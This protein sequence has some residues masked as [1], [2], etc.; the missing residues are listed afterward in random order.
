M[1]FACIS[2]HLMQKKIVGIGK[3]TNFSPK[4]M[5]FVE[6]DSEAMLATLSY[7]IMTFGVIMLV[8]N[9][10]GRASCRERV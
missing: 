8:T 6:Y 10:I 9:E 3:I 1:I 4:V 7:I 5:H 2:G